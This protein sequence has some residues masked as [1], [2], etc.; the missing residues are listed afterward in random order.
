MP[1]DRR[2]YRENRKPS[3]EFLGLI[4]PLPV[5]E[6]AKKHVRPRLGVQYVKHFRLMSNMLLEAKAL[7]LPA[8]RS[9]S[10][11]AWPLYRIGLIFKREAISVLERCKL[12]AHRT[13]KGP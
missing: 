8:E 5:R 7:L 2:S 1:V 12:P 11:T 3:A 4:L 13:T 10:P 6:L 9:N